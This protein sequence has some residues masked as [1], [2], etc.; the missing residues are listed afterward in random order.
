RGVAGAPRA[1]LS[2]LAQSGTPVASLVSEEEVKYLVREGTAQGVFEAAERDLVNRVFEFADTPVRLVMGPR[3]NIVA[4]NIDT[5]P[6]E[7]LM[8]AARLGHTRLP[9]FRG[10]IEDALGVGGI[11]GLFRWAALAQPVNLA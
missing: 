2:A 9:V 5:P 10:S 6:A 3:P 4:L 1:L 7:V 8:R 11:K